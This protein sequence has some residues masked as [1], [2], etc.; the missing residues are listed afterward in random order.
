MSA[1]RRHAVALLSC[2]ALAACEGDFFLVAGEGTLL[3]GVVTR[4]P[5]QP[6][7]HPDVP[8]D[9]PFSSGFTATRDGRIVAAF[10]SGADGRFRVA[11]PS[12]GTFRIVPG[13]EAP[14]LDPTIQSREVSVRAGEVNEV[15]LQFDTGIR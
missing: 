14:L 6:V 8:C 13:P 5:T 15:A 12:G 3:V 2:L 1:S 4:S 7:C 10:H 11:L 9:A